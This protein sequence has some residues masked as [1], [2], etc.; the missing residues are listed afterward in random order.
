MLLARTSHPHIA[1]LGR[2]PGTNTYSDLARHPDNEELP[3]AIAFRPEA[4]HIYINSDN[5][6][7]AVLNRLRGAKQA[8]IRVVVCD[9]SASPYIDLA[10]S[11]MLHEL[12]TELSSRAIALRIVGAHGLVR[13]L[14]RADGL[15]D[16]VGGLDRA[17]SLCDVLA[18]RQAN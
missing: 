10:G 2:I 14:L 5:V 6:L 16:K 11:H 15:E 1:F 17:M 12:H 8:N 13:D 4:S 7:E 3:E 18:A 9:L